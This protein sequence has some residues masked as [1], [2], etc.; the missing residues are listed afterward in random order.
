MRLYCCFY[1]LVFCNQ[2]IFKPS[3]H[4]YTHICMHKLV[5][6]QTSTLTLINTCTFVIVYTCTHLHERQ[7]Y[8]LFS[9]V[10]HWSITMLCRIFYLTIFRLLSF[11][12]CPICS[13][14]MWY[15]A[16]GTSPSIF[17]ILLFVYLFTWLLQLHLKFT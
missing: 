7:S 8:Q 13:I 10:N 12:V 16:N 3:T 17:W 4:I 1:L 2:Y 15:H 11:I 5:Y 14:W 6:T 9:F